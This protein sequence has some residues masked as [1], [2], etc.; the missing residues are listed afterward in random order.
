MRASFHCPECDRKT[1]HVREDVP[2]STHILHALACLFTCG[3]WLP[4]WIIHAM[5]GGDK[6]YRCTFCGRKMA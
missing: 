6:F 2:A 1:A 5:T 4:V 3:I